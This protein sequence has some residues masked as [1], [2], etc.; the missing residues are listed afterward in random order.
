MAGEAYRVSFDDMRQRGS[1]HHDDQAS[2]AT[3]TRR[4]QKQLLPLTYR[5][6]VGARVPIPY[7][8][9]WRTPPE[10]P[11]RHAAL[12]VAAACLTG[13]RCDA[14]DRSRRPRAARDRDA[15]VDVLR[16]AVEL[17]VNHIDT[18]QYNGLDV[19]NKVIRES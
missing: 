8:Q 6:A 2:P 9:P 4:N 10:R 15:A 18:A 19:V 11:F 12:D 14:V 13:L 7:G 1:A 5:G 16:K 3:R 17:G